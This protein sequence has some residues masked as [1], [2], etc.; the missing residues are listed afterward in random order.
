MRNIH[1][2]AIVFITFLFVHKVHA[3][4]FQNLTNPRYVHSDISSAV[5][6]QVKFIMSHQN[7]SDRN[8]ANQIVVKVIDG[9]AVQTPLAG[10]SSNSREILFTNGFIWLLHGYVEAY[11]LEA[12]QRVRPHF[13]EWWV[14]HAITR[15]LPGYDGKPPSRPAIFAGMSNAE[16]KKF[17]NQTSRHLE[18]VFLRTVVEILLHEIGHHVLNA[19]YDD[20][21][22]SPSMMKNA[23]KA[24][25]NW[26]RLAWQKAARKNPKLFGGFETNTIGRLTALSLLK[27]MELFL[28]L[29]ENGLKASRSHPDLSFRLQLILGHENCIVSNNKKFCDWV[30]ARLKYLQ[31]AYSSSE[32]YKKRAASGEIHAHL[33]LG[34]IAARQGRDHYP[35]ACR[36]FLNALTKGTYGLRDTSVYQY[37]GWC[38][39]NKYI[40][41]HLPESATDMLAKKSFRKASK[42]GWLHSRKQLQFFD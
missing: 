38:Y 14:R 25:D 24:A 2:S 5:N 12:S 37:I 13:T 34:E 11:F 22:D 28:T 26:A 41:K 10:V 27:D 4:T 8:I 31:R 19:F 7:E 18:L 21:K 29:D 42:L 39:Q 20:K 16:Y 32:N 30:Y 33:R 1:I 35:E 36:H 40:G 23:E 15:S 9:S 6:G 17:L 3:Q